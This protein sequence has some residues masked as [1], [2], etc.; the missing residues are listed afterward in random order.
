[1]PHISFQSPFLEYFLWH[2]FRFSATTSHRVE[3][4]ACYFISLT[5]DVVEGG[6]RSQYGEPW[7]KCPYLINCGRNIT[8]WTYS[9]CLVIYELLM[10]GW[11]ISYISVATRDSSN[12]RL[13]LRCRHSCCKTPAYC[14]C[15][16]VF[17]DEWKWY[18]VS[19]KNCLIAI[20]LSASNVFM[21][22]NF[23][24]FCVCQ[25]VVLGQSLKCCCSM[26]QGWDAA[27]W[28][29]VAENR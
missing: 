12:E 5:L 24:L 2:H 25:S 13:Q 14:T 10:C 9:F 4:W 19:I 20:A 21:R 17:T 22:V 11:S 7:I 27:R 1:M 15:A 16:K 8:D 29:C 3:V 6:C 18:M 28:V 23:I 26:H